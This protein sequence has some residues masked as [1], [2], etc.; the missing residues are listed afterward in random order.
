MAKNKHLTLEQRHTIETGINQRESFKEI[1]RRIDKDCT[2]ISKEIKNHRVFKNTGALG[3]SFNDCKNRIGCSVTQ[4][5]N[6]CHRKKGALCT[7][8]GLCIKYCP[9][10]ERETCRALS[11]PPYVCNGCT[12][13]KK[14]TLQKAEY[15]AYASQKEYEENL[16]ES[17]QGANATA[18]DI[19]HLN[20][21]ISPLLK[22]GQSL[23]H[24]Y[25]NH[26]NEIMCCE[27]TLYSYVDDCLLDAR[28]IDMPIKVRLRPRK[29]NT[30]H[31]K[32]DPA[33]RVG[34]TI[35]DF[36]QF[37]KDHPDLP[38]TELDSVE[39]VRG[40]PVLLTIHS[41]NPKMQL[42]FKRAHNDAQ[43]VID[44]FN[45]LY[46]KLGAEDYARIFPVLLA[47]NGSEF[48]NPKALEYSLDGKFRSYVFYCDPS[49]P[50]QKGHC[51]N[52]HKMIR[53]IIPKG[54]DI[55]LYSDEQISL[56]MNHINSYGRPELG[57]KSPYEVF[58]F[59]YGE[60][61][62]RK[63]NVKRIPRDKIILKPSL[64]NLPL[65]SSTHEA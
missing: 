11:C 33:C 48:S 44:V 32:I 52:N 4:I 24:I 57:D 27:K 50:G 42:F 43:S 35:E 53:R 54:K 8:C 58:A 36:H 56:M 9:E 49:A 63:L 60:E 12:D 15:S 61:I 37:M 62:L 25:V 64:M 7:F 1:G 14:C 20:A 31:V 13:K 47:D 3:R 2:T 21:L 26:S 29:G 23:H 65:Q 19:E 40:G 17:R 39:G 55:G 45:D 6:N 59:F 22:N 28:N 46:E 34:R 30:P 41:I 16:T 10:Y 51:E 38:V 18:E 5:C